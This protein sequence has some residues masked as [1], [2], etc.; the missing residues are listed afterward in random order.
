MEGFFQ[1][2]ESARNCHF[3]GTHVKCQK[4]W[5][6]PGTFLQNF[7]DNN[8]FIY[9]L[10]NTLVFSVTYFCTTETHTDFYTRIDPGD[11]PEAEAEAGSNSCNGLQFS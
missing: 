5:H 2:Q 7:Y 8:T 3:P 11:R 10:N 6:F 4:T 9:F 1:C